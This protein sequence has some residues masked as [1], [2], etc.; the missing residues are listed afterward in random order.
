MPNENEKKPGGGGRE[1][2]PGPLPPPPPRAP[3]PG[4]RLRGCQSR[5][6]AKGRGNPLGTETRHR[7]EGTRPGEGGTQ[8][9]GLAA[10]PSRPAD[11]RLGPCP[12]HRPRGASQGSRSQPWPQPP[13]TG[14]AGA[15]AIVPRRPRGSWRPRSGAGGRTAAG[16]ASSRE[17][18]LTHPG[19][20]LAP[21]RPQIEGGL[22]SPGKRSCRARCTRNTGVTRGCW[23][24]CPPGTPPAGPKPA[25]DRLLPP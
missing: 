2:G 8:L 23:P 18:P 15:A 4:H 10:A 3:L 5:G 19:R 14:T 11:G 17:P 25:G 7:P 24:R 9:L 12:E 21:Y 1:G 20:G 6:R 22:L 13:A 16:P